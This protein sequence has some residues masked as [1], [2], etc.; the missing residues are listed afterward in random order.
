MY[1]APRNFDCEYLGEPCSD[2]RCRRGFC[3]P[4]MEEHALNTRLEPAASDDFRREVQKVAR[5]WLKWIKGI[6]KPSDDQVR[7]VAQL[8]T[9][10]D[11]ARR[12]VKERRE[13]LKGLQ[14]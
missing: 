11:E 4:A 14:P 1:V 2:G 10:I 3:F 5:D 9:A 7:R 13:V 12:R 6:A 8:P